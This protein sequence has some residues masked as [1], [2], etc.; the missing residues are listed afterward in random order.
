MCVCVCVCV[1][2]YTVYVYIFG[3]GGDAFDQGNQRFATRLCGYEIYICDLSIYL[4]RQICI[5]VFLY[6]CVHVQSFGGGGDAFDQGNQ[7]FATRLC[8][9]KLI[10]M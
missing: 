8:G 2:L 6:A 1:Y 3:G 9:Y 5:L 10:H 4:C 7:R